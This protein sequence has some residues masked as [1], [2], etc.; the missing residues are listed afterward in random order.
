MTAF[1]HSGIEPAEPGGDCAVRRVARMEVLAVKLGSNFEID[2][3]RNV[4]RKAR[5]DRA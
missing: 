1:S 2:S 3:L 4:S 5:N